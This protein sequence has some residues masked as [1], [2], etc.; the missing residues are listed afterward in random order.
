MD[1]YPDED[2]IQLSAVQHFVFCKR[3]CYLIHQE[4]FWSDN[5]FTV[6]GTLAH[7]RVDSDAVSYSPD[8]LKQVRSLLLSSTK[9]G[10][11]GR[12]DLIEFDE[13]NGKVFSVEYKV[14]K[15]KSDNRD[16]VQLCAQ[17]FCLEEMLNF[18]VPKGAIYYGRSHRR[19]E[20]EFNDKL[21]KETEEI[22]RQVH[23]LFRL[24]EPPPPVEDEEKCSNCSLKD[25]CLPVLSKRRRV[26]RYLKKM[27]LDE[28]SLT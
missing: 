22:I 14:G 2:V 8:G 24:D 18:S 19:L 25:Y 3:Q 6:S 17:A 1:G 16:A 20:I 21:R 27:L 5:I 7:Q 9:Y 13:E 28:G 26:D 4:Q 11:S 12:A 15:P 10:L 23:E